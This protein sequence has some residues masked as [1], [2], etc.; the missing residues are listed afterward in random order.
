MAIEQAGKGS[1][2]SA[3]HQPHLPQLAGL[4]G[5][6]KSYAE[7]LFDFPVVGALAESEA[8]GALAIPAADQG[9]EIASGALGITIDRSGGYPYFPQEWGSHVWNLAPGPTVI[10]QE[11]AE[12]AEPM[13]TGQLDSNFLRVRFDRLTPKE[14]EYVRAMAAL[15]PGPHR[16]GDIAARLGVRVES[17][18]PRRSG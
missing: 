1:P 15:G 14:K 11:D 6:A 4:A 2:S 9:V 18:A 3:P 7:R 12:A 10:T 17:V 13:V 8:R 5:E 16:S